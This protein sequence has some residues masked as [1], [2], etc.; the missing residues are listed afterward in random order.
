MRRAG[1]GGQFQPAAK[2][3]SSFRTAITGRQPRQR[4]KGLMPVAQPVL[5]LKASMPNRVTTPSISL[6]ALK[7][8]SISPVRIRTRAA[9]SPD[10]P[11]QRSRSVGYR[12]QRIQLS[13]RWIVSWRWGH[14]HGRSRGRSQHQSHRRVL[15]SRVHLAQVSATCSARFARSSTSRCSRSLRI[16][17]AVLPRQSSMTQRSGHRS[18]RWP[19]RAMARAP[20]KLT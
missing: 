8:Q 16:F 13:A 19:L 3:A 12:V 18:L 9:E 6:L 1:A 2:Q 20:E 5:V 4:V 17:A 11:A 7:T 10:L 15:N 14:R